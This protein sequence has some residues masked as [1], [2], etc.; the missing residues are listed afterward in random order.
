MTI[1]SFSKI[2]FSNP[3]IFIIGI[4]TLMGNAASQ[5]HHIGFVAAHLR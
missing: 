1:F 4:F 3:I 2:Q 5:S